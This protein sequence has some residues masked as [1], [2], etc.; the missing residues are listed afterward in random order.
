MTRA[1]VLVLLFPLTAWVTSQERWDMRWFAAG[2][3]FLAGLA[4]WLQTLVMTTQTPFAALIATQALGGVGYAFIFVPLSVVLFKTVPQA[5]IPSALA[6][7]RLVQQIGASVG[8]AL[9]ATFLDRNYAAALNAL[10][11][12]ASLANPAVASLLAGHG[13][14]ALTTLNAL[15]EA[16]ATNLSAVGTTQFFALVTMAAAVLP[17]LLARNL[18]HAPLPPKAQPPEPPI[19]ILRGSV[20]PQRSLV[21]R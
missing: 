11:P 18:G 13:P 2:G 19:A 12:S 9:A 14:N 10:A 5:S 3:I 4:S 20:E 8:S 1:G 7:T 17:F 16:Q 21:L 15:V 6:L